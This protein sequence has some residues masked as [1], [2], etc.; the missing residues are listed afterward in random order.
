MYLVLHIKYTQK[1]PRKLH[2]KDKT[3]DGQKP[4]W[5]VND[6]RA[7]NE[8]LFKF[9]SS[10]VLLKVTGYFLFSFFF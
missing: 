7:A 4:S 10:S 3:K 8:L 6:A 2:L 9:F 5:W 1:T